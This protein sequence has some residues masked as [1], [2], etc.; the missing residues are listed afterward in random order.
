MSEDDLHNRLSKAA[1]H[2]GSDESDVARSSLE[3]LLRAGISSFPQLV[4]TV[5]DPRA[6]LSV[7]IEGCRL[8]A[9]LGDASASAGLVRA[10]ANADD[11]GLVWEASKALARLQAEQAK[12]TLL[13]LLDDQN[14]AKQAAAAWVLGWLRAGDAAPSLQAT[15]ENVQRPTDVRS[16][17]IEALGVMKARQ[18]V[19]SLIRLLSDELPEVRYWAAY[20]LGQIGD[21]ESVHEL[22]R[23][24]ST[25]DGMLPDGRLVRDEA[26]DALSRLGN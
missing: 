1:E 15:A 22:E 18:S 23:I 21:P 5:A 17:A 19:Q 25:D 14:F 10:L 16:H 24:A 4:D 2:L 9:W 3:N 12:P 8:L 13:R 7:R 6:M 26:I 20:A 11:D